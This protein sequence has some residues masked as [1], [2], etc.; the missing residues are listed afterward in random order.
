MTLLVALSATSDTIEL[1]DS[2]ELG[3][4]SQ[5]ALDVGGNSNAP[6]DA[7]S[8]ETG[9][10]DGLLDDKDKNDAGPSEAVE[11]RVPTKK[12]TPRCV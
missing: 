1:P 9:E 2:S 4:S 8:S 7:I 12:H 3:G 10:S 5:K 6:T 11:S